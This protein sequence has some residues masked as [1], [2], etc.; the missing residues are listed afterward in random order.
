[1]RGYLSPLNY[2]LGAPIYCVG[3]TRPA[4]IYTGL[5]IALPLIYHFGYRIAAYLIYRFGYRRLALA[6]RAWRLSTALAV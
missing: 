3:Y 6:I 1:M 4:L 5:A 2:R